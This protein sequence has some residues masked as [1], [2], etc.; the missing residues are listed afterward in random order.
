MKELIGNQD[1][2]LGAFPV[3]FEILLMVRLQVL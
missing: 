1:K 3:I 2:A